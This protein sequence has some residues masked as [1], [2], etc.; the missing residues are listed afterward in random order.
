[1]P[2][3]PRRVSEALIGHPAVRRVNFTGSSR[4]GNGIVA[5]T[6]AKYLKPVLLELGGKA[7]LIVLEDADLDGRRQ[8]HRVLARSPT[9]GQICMST[10]AG[11][12]AREG[13]R[14]ICRQGSPKRVAGLPS[15]DPARKGEVVLGSVIGRPTVA[16]VEKLV[17]A[18]VAQGAKV[19]VGGEKTSNTPHERCRGRSRDAEK[20]DLF[21]ER[22][23]GPARVDHPRELRGRGRWP[24]PTTPSTVCRPRSLPATLPRGLE[25]AKRID[26]GHH[27]YQLP[28][29]CRMRRRCPSVG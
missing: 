22:L 13:C 29:R 10:G 26:A 8:C 19:L 3:T 14:R 20:W 21:R 12:G 7:P 23:S 6:G 17:A 2:R 4:V 27:P 16:H 5:Q 15:G 25:L 1:M 28:L 11:G 9:S 24:S 18:A